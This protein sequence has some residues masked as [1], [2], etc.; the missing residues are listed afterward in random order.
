LRFTKAVGKGEWREER[1]RLGSIDH[2]SY[3]AT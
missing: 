1:E 3:G 2:V